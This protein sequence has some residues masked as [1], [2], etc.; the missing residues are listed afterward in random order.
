LLRLP[1][2]QRLVRLA[3]GQLTFD[4]EGNEGGRYH[5]RKA[6]VPGP[7]SGVTIGRGYDLSGR[8]A[9]AIKADLKAAGVTAPE[10]LSEQGVGGSPSTAPDPLFAQALRR[11]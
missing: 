1:P 9:D 6:Q 4:F 8:D 3:G 5:I 7:T 2:L 10:R 11:G